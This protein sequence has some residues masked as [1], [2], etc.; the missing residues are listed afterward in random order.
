MQS[1]KSFKSE[2][3]VAALCVLAESYLLG[4]IARLNPVLRTI[5]ADLAT[6]PF[7]ALYTTELMTAVRMEA[8]IKLVSPYSRLK[9]SHVAAELS[10]SQAEAESIL[11]GLIAEHRLPNG[12]AIDQLLQ[13]LIIGNGGGGSTSAGGHGLFDEYS[14]L[15]C[16]LTDKLQ[17]LDLVGQQQHHHSKY[18][19]HDRFSMGGPMRMRPFRS[20]G[21]HGSGGMGG[22]RVYR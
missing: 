7:M 10:V 5:S 22:P 21:G 19:R 3:E 11:A 6:D 4:D 1:V 9:I 13:V 16:G 17:K 2:P 18:G 14:K 20:D 8:C 15:L 12:S